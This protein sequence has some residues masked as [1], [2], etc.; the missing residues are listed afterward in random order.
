MPAS[1]SRWGSLDADF[2]NAGRNS[3]GTLSAAPLIIGRQ[4]WEILIAERQVRVEVMFAVEAGLVSDFCFQGQAGQDGQVDGCLIEYWQGAR[5]AEAER[6]DRGI[7]WHLNAAADATGAKSLVFVRSWT[8]HSMPIV[9]KKP[10]TSPGCRLSAVHFRIAPI[11]FK[12]GR[13]LPELFGLLFVEL[14][15]HLVDQAVTQL[16]GPPDAFLVGEQPPS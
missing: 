6:A 8:W 13:R 11:S 16:V 2:K 1:A 5:Q 10:S 12:R 15:I 4:C 3:V 9:G 14:D 7:G